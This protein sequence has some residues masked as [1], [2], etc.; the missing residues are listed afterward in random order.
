[1]ECIFTSTNHN[2]RHVAPLGMCDAK[3]IFSQEKN[4]VFKI[5][6]PKGPSIKP[7]TWNIPE[8]PGT[9]KNKIKIPKKKKKGKNEKTKQNKTN[10]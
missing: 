5:I 3:E 9:R 8:H 10:E 2:S 7:G 1:M 6:P 4:G